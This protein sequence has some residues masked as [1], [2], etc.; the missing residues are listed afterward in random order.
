MSRDEALAPWRRAAIVAVAVALLACLG[1]AFLAAILARQFRALDLQRLDL[2]ASAGALSSSERRLQENTAILR[3]TLQAIDEGVMMVSAEGRVVLC[4]ERAMELLD[5]PRE[6]LAE[7][8]MFER[9]LQH[10]WENNEFSRTGTSLVEFIKAGG[11]AKSPRSYE[12]ARPDGS[13][14]EIRTTTLPGGAIVRSYIDITERRRAEELRAARDEADRASRAKS[15]FL[16]TM[17]HEIR[18]PMSGLLGVL[19]LLRATDLGAEQRRMADMVQNSGA[20]LLAVLN[21]I[22]DFS[23]IEA[24]ALTIESEPAQLRPLLADLVQPHAAAAR[25]KGLR[26]QLTVAPDLPEWI[27]TDKL[28]LRQIIGNLLSNAIKFTIAGDIAVRV[29]GD[30]DVDSPHLLFEVQ[31]SGIGMSE[32]VLARLFN[33]FTQADASTT[34]NFGGTGLGLSISRRLAGLMEGDLSVA[35]RLGEGSTFTLRL[36]MR[37]CEPPAAIEAAPSPDALPLPPGRRVLVVDDDPTIRWLSQ[38]QLET[39]GCVVQVA[40]DGIDAIAALDAGHFDLVLTDCHMPR[41]DGVALTCAI[42]AAADPARRALPIIGLTADVTEAQRDACTAAGM[43]VLAIKPLTRE[44]LSQLLAAHLPS[45]AAQPGVMRPAAAAAPALRAVAFDDQIYLEIFER[46]DA[47]GADWVLES[48]AALRAD[49][50]ELGHLV[51][52]HPPD[53]DA[54]ATLAHRLAGSSFSL[55]AMLMGDA[56]RALERAAKRG[57]TDGVRACQAALWDALETATSAVDE[58]LSSTPQTAGN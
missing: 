19:E 2:L 41:M 42:R 43:S 33:P 12:R 56:A 40:S 22:L 34:R 44:R 36:P 11:L 14:L 20:I 25:H 6:L 51:E 29:T 31:D 15:E 55:G 57:E 8:P 18:S 9:I 7:Q 24:G 39:L 47:A 52:I 3:T 48:L 10:Q 21:D 26:V 58:F 49:V 54:I 50:A 4:N 1:F 23:K 28:R 37:A 53:F 45:G 5:L 27:V 46:G 35:S 16:A 32:D 38:R 30:G 13:F 17:S